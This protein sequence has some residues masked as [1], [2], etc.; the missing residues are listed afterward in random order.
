[1][2]SLM[3]YTTAGKDT[4]SLLNCDHSKSGDWPVYSA[5][6][7]G[8]FLIWHLS[9]M[10]FHGSL[11]CNLER[12]SFFSVKLDFVSSELNCSEARRSHQRAAA[13]RLR[14]V[15]TRIRSG[16]VGAEARRRCPST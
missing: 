4:K 1:M 12:Y 7:R 13:G 3:L 8:L 9:V 11:R 10:A 6:V 14:S 5:A 15:E 2:W 16:K